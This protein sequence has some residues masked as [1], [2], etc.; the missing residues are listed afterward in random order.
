VPLGTGQFEEEHLERMRES[1]AG[2][3]EAQEAVVVFRRPGKLPE[4]T[5]AVA[6]PVAEVL[7]SIDGIREDIAIEASVMV[8]LA[9]AISVLGFLLVTFFT[10]LLARDVGVPLRRTAAEA[11]QITRNL[12]HADLFA[13]IVQD[14]SARN[15]SSIG[16]LAQ[17]RYGYL[18]MLEDLAA[19]RAR[20][21]AAQKVGNPFFA[22]AAL[23]AGPHDEELLP[24][25]LPPL[26]DEVDP[27]LMA[28]KQAF[29][30]AAAAGGKSDDDATGEAATGGPARR[31]K[32]PRVSR[33]NSLAAHMGVLLRLPLLLALSV[34]VGMVV[35]WAVVEG[36]RWV[37]PVMDQMVRE[38]VD[39]LPGRCSQ[40]AE[41]L[42]NNFRVAA[43]SLLMLRDHA[44]GVFQGRVAVGPPYPSYQAGGLDGRKPTL[45][46]GGL[47]TGN[48]RDGKAPAG[49]NTVASGWYRHPVRSPL[50]GAAFTYTGPDPN[51][52]E[53]LAADLERLAHLENTARAIYR[54]V[55]GGKFENIYWGM[56]QTEIF[57][58]YPFDQVMESYKAFKGR[59]AR[60]KEPGGRTG[61]RF[62]G[63]TPLCRD[64]YD[65]AMK[66]TEAV[67]F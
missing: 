51:R 26:G 1:P 13:G 44:E 39:S 37:R 9:L 41:L 19:R 50:T 5:M 14:L 34:T 17:L 49:K 58:M 16:E 65:E 57:Q 27:G 20:R 48:G 32:G 3:F 24:L 62:E 60:P 12:G 40:R 18:S 38:E 42:E 67:V 54:S 22:E 66:G 36:Q 61:W 29:A 46:P 25:P 21:N 56:E 8:R 31:P 45:P 43:I 10:C 64:W 47:G 15:L 33:T 30:D 53:E 23:P 52:P 28:L 63:Y 11:A 6:T 4:F 35:L 7:D 2:N 59:C 55:E